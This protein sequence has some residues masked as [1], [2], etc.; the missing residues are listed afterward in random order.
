MALATA[1]DEELRT[2]FVSGLPRDATEREMYLLCRLCPGYEGCSLAVTA[3][4]GPLAFVIFSSNALALAAMESLQGTQFDPDGAHQLRIELAKKNSAPKRQR[5]EGDAGAAARRRFAPSTTPSFLPPGS[6][7]PP[8]D[9]FGAPSLY[10]PFAQS[11][12]GYPGQAPYGI[13]LPPPAKP[14]HR[15][16]NPAGGGCT[17]FIAG[18]GET[19]NEAIIRAIFGQ[20]AGLKNVKFKPG[21]FGK[22]A[23]AWVQYDNPE[24]A[25]AAKAIYHGTSPMGAA[26]PEGLRVEYAKTEMSSGS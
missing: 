13:G 16:Q 10:D 9:P 18:L 4:G 6:V 14:A 21:E 17:L 12:Y 5:P 15:P 24:A 26:G 25:S 11:P 20:T 19:A 3:G 22:H 8:Y 7:P 23:A 1:M 2:L